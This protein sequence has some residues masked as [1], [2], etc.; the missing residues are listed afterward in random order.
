MVDP[1]AISYEKQEP[2]REQWK[3]AWACRLQEDCEA[4]GKNKGMFRLHTRFDADRGSAA[5]DYERPATLY[6]FL[7]RLDNGAISYTTTIHNHDIAYTLSSAFA[8][9]AKYIERF[10]I[11]TPTFQIDF[12][13]VRKLVLTAL[14]LASKYLDDDCL[15]LEEFA[16]A[17]GITTAALIRLE[18][19]MA[20]QIGFHLYVTP[21]EFQETINSWT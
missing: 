1:L 13:N 6:D 3:K 10:L 20:S 18:A 11:R 9:A 5:P 21:D 8:I 7:R 19:Y 2:F 15:A 14:L 16:K 4:Q 12:E 17:G